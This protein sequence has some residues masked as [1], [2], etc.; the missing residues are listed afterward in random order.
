MKP[1]IT[2]LGLSAAFVL[3]S[4]TITPKPSI[5]EPAITISLSNDINRTLALQNSG[6]ALIN[7]SDC[8]GCHKKDSQLIGPSYKDIAKKYAKT[9]K[10][11]NLLASKI[12][13]GGTGVWG[14][15]PMTPHPKL[16]NADAK[17]M[18]KYIFSLKK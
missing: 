9:E 16:S 14:Q 3:T 10:N 1:L 12:I 2:I 17:L 6:E 13:K 8:I 15:I 7:K 4:H 18:V 5:S 11:I